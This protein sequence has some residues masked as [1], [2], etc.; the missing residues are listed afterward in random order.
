MTYV[1]YYFFGFR[2]LHL[3]FLVTLR[4]LMEEFYHVTSW[5]SLYLY[6]GTYLT[7]LIYLTWLTLGST[8]LTC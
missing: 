4:S 5:A 7:Y 6:F 2:P 3:T 8:Y 1:I